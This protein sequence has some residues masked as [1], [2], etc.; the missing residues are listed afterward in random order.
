[1]AEISKD[2]KIGST[3]S[4]RLLNPESL[5]YD[6]NDERVMARDSFIKKVVFYEILLSHVAIRDAHNSVFS[7]SSF[8]RPNDVSIFPFL[9]SILYIGRGMREGEVVRV[10][11]KPNLALSCPVAQ[12]AMNRNCSGCPDSSWNCLILVN[13]HSELTRNVSNL[14]LWVSPLTI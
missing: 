11:A 9:L 1:M 4:P 7:P 5:A 2:T 6:D 13:F 14:V 3:G 10:R 8:E 12:A